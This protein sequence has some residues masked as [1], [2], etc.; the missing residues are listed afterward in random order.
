[1]IRRTTGIILL[2]ASSLA[3]GDEPHKAPDVVRVEVAGAGRPMLLLPG[4]GCSG[5]V[6]NDTVAHFKDRY[7]CHSFTFAGFGG[8]PPIEGRYLPKY[9]DAVI[10]YVKTKNLKKP[11]I[12][13]HS[14]GG[15]LAYAVAAAIPDDVGAVIVVDAALWSPAVLMP[16][17]KM[18]DARKQAAFF[19]KRLRD[20]KPQQFA[21]QMNKLLPPDTKVQDSGKRAVVNGMNAA[22]HI[23][24]C[25]DVMCE[26]L[27]TDLRGEAKK[28]KA[29]VLVMIAGAAQQSNDE[30][31]AKRERWE[32][33][34]KPIANCRVVMAVKANHFIPLDD[35]EFAHRTMDDFLGEKGR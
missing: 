3:A 4:V 25:V 34:L 16:G 32:A 10:A 19:R 8:L 18:D 29:P 24:T 7:E 31:D 21:E 6:W 1:M 28:I 14:V 35:P 30:Q 33:H 27:T 5:A 26:I 11:V 23:P 22:S 12:V 20:L 15:L 17:M 2:A 9:R 13:G